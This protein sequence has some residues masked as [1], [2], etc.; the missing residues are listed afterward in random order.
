MLPTWLQHLPREKKLIIITIIIIIIIIITKIYSALIYRYTEQPCTTTV[1]FGDLYPAFLL[2]LKLEKKHL[3]EKGSNG[4]GLGDWSLLWDPGKSPGA[5]M[6][7]ETWRQSPS[8]SPP[9]EVEKQTTFHKN[10]FR[11]LC[12]HNTLYPPPKS[13]CTMSL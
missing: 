7:M 6:P 4:V 10:D 5:P 2:A 13:L 12:I 1:Q 9:P 3:W 8:S 11:D